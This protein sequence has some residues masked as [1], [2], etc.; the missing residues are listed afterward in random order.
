MAAETLDFTKNQGDGLSNEIVWG[1]NLHHK[2]FSMTFWYVRGEIDVPY[3]NKNSIDG[4]Q[5]RTKYWK[6]NYLKYYQ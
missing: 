5:R 2:Y 1:R 3:N 4:L 6:K